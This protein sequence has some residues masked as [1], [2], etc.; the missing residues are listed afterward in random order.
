[1]KKRIWIIV[2][3]ILIAVLLICGCAE[4]KKVDNT[5]LLSRLNEKIIEI[6]L[7]H[8]ESGGAVEASDIVIEQIFYGSFSQPKAKEVLVICKLL[9]TPHTGGLDRRACVILEV[10]TM[11][12]GAYI[13]LGADEALV[14][15]LS[16]R[17]GQDRMIFLGQSTYQGLSTQEVMCFSVQD[18]QWTEM[19]IGEVKELG[20]GCFCFRIDDML[21]VTSE[22]KLVNPSGITAILTWDADTG[23]FVEI[24]RN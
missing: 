18:G 16:M 1:M 22:R 5:E 17:N 11:E 10:D 15:K 21:V 4:I 2:N 14:Y 6:V 24:Y 7:E 3:F 23:Q 9:N 8:D 19:E 20:E 13:E 12:A